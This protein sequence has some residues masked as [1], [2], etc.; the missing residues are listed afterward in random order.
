M[1]KRTIKDTV[2]IPVTFQYNA[3]SVDQTIFT[4]DRAYKVKAIYVRPRV[5]GSDA[6]AVTAAVKKAASGTA[7][8][9]GTAVH[10]GTADLKG[11]ADTNQ[12]LT[13]STTAANLKLTAGQSLC[14]DFTGVMTAA[15]GTITV[16]LIPLV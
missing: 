3:S 5:A 1:K 4:A 9:D 8:A 2:Q 15:V 6:G 7:P 11:T 12:Q 10:S 16:I 14:V 13:L